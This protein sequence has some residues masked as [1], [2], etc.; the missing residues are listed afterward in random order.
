[1]KRSVTLFALLITLS[2]SLFAQKASDKSLARV[3][4]INGVEAYILSEPLRQY[5]VL[6]DVGTGI[7][8]E[9][10]LTGGLINKTIS[11][12]VEQFIRKVQK[13]NAKIDAVVYSA[14][15]RIV[16]IRFKDNGGQDTNGIGRVSKVNGYPV[17]VMSEPLADYETL[18]SKGGGIKWKSLVTGGVINNSIEED[19]E[20]MVKKLDS[21]GAE[22]MMFEGGKD[23]AAIRFR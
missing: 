20:S 10:L 18:N 14:G 4:K 7:K 13:D 1:M 9:S 22:G 17:Y 8:A 21:R 23:G 3:R 16:G 15:K 11:G 2:T 12:K 5:D 19:V 6:V